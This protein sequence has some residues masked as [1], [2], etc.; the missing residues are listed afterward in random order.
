MLY[1][2]MKN[3]NFRKFGKKVQVKKLEKTT[4]FV[5]FKVIT[6]FSINLKS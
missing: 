4:L 3:Q 2:T 5:V 6:F 1:K